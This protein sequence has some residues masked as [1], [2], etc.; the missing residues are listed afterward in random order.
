MKGFRS[1]KY[2]KEVKTKII[3]KAVEAEMKITLE[4][5]KA[6]LLRDCYKGLQ[7]KKNKVREKIVK[8]K[9]LKLQESEKI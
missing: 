9:F 4:E 2:I 5:K 6:N 1:T 8:Q 3:D 7:I